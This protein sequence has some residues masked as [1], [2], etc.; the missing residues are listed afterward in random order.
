MSRTLT[1]PVP[2][3]Q[4]GINYFKVMKCQR[5]GHVVRS[6]STE[7]IPFLPGEGVG[8]G[9]RDRCT[10]RVISSYGADPRCQITRIVYY[11][12]IEGKLRGMGGRVTRGI[13][14]F[15]YTSRRSLIS[16]SDEIFK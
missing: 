4:I 12:K 13:G 3:Y 9:C 8:G 15:N 16:L 5:R 14:H 11:P 10:S 2:R 1:T 7:D 6:Y